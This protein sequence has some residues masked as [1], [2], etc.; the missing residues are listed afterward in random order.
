MRPRHA[1]CPEKWMSGRGMLMPLTAREIEI[2]KREDERGQAGR[3]KQMSCVDTG[4]RLARTL[5]PQTPIKTGRS[6][7]TRS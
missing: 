4:G 2:I 6:D 7:L 3:L 5:W 1:A